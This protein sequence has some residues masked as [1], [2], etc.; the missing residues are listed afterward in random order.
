M[1][2]PRSSHAF[3]GRASELSRLEAALDAAAAGHDNDP[4]VARRRGIER[5]IK[6]LQLAR[7]ADECA[8]AAGPLHGARIIRARQGDSDVARS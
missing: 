8:A 4:A 7:P 5:G 2:G 3:V 6:L 1:E